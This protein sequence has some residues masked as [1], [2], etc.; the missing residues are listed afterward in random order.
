M[1]EIEF[2]GISIYSHEWL[3]GDLSV[4]SA[5]H[6]WDESKVFIVERRPL[7][8]RFEVIPETVGQFTGLLDKN[9]K[10]I[11]EGDI[12]KY[13][14]KGYQWRAVVLWDEGFAEYRKYD[15]LD[16]I[17]PSEYDEELSKCSIVIG[18]IHENPELLKCES[19]ES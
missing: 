18:N 12:I 2:R 19:Q 17:R 5:E 8:E 6:G 10:K 9:G 1:R 3:Y 13:G 11:Y 7:F 16:R 14:Y 4:G 15:T